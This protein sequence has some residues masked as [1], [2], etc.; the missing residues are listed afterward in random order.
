MAQLRLHLLGPFRAFQDGAPVTGFESNKVRALLAYLAVESD[1]LH[2]RESLAGLL[3]P[4][5]PDRGALSNLRYALSDLRLVLGD[6]EAD[7]HYLFVTRDSI[8]VNPL[9]DLWLDVAQ[10]LDTVAAQEAE[11]MAMGLAANGASGRLAEALD[12]YVG[13]FLDGF[14]VSGSAP[15]EE[16]ALFKRE[17]IG[18]QALW[19]MHALAGHCEAVGDLD[20]A[21]RYARRQIALE[22]WSEDAHRQ[23]MRSLAQSG[24]RNAALKQYEVCRRLLMR[25]LGVEPAE[26]TTALYRQ[27]RSRQTETGPAYVREAA[28]VVAGSAQFETSAATAYAQSNPGP[29][30]TS[31]LGVPAQ[32]GGSALAGAVSAGK[33]LERPRDVPLRIG[34]VV[35]ILW[36]TIVSVAGLLHIVLGW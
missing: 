15:F 3:W 13:P 10:L 14:S 5:M 23:V 32:A 26:E 36:A 8:G 29:A 18:R 27:I 12:L 6:R 31:D 19:A 33:P 22:P 16:W 25:E 35:A 7:P 24:Q 21:C 1:Q 30:P 4:E 17:Q 28:A 11:T 34:L 20:G 9:G 2:R